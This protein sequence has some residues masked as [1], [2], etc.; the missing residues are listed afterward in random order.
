MVDIMI[1]VE[2]GRRDESR[3]RATSRKVSVP[4]AQREA[5]EARAEFRFQVESVLFGS[6][7][8]DV[9]CLQPYWTHP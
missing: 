5:S 3:V 6:I 1:S 9:A 2:Q 8:G 4:I 7:L